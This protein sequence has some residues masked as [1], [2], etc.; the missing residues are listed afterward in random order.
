[1]EM[2]EDYLDFG[3][4][5]DVMI[6]PAIKGCKKCHIF[7]VTMDD[8]NTLHMQEADGKETVALEVVRP[9]YQGDVDWRK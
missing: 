5:Q 6:L 2:D 3:V 8:S 4:L 9:Q 1:M 7:T